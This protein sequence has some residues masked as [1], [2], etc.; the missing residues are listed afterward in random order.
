MFVPGST[1]IPEWISHQK[2]GFKMTM[3]LPCSWYKNDDFLGFVLCSLYAPLDNEWMNTNNSTN[4]WTFRCNLDLYEVRAP[5]HRNDSQVDCRINYSYHKDESNRVWLIYYSKSNIPKRFHSNGQKAMEASFAVDFGSNR[6]NADRCGF[7]FLYAHD[8]EHYNPT[9]E[10]GSSSLGDLGRHR[11][12]VQDI[13]NI[14]SQRSCD[15]ARSSVD[16][17]DHSTTQDIDDNGVDA[18]DHVM[19]HIHRWLELLRLFIGYICC[20]RD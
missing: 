12:V 3:E 6:V 2:N 9:L 15:I 7:H 1:G 5:L 11:S 10:Q 20:T 8:Y 4:R 19:D 18:Q 16:G 13:N 17:V 14:H